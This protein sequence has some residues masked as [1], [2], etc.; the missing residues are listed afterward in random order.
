MA[1]GGNVTVNGKRL[2][3]RLDLRNH[4]PDGFNWGYGGSGPAQLALAILAHEFGDDQ[5]ALTLYQPFKWGVIAP[6]QDNEWELTSQ[7]INAWVIEHGRV[8]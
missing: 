5:A 3:T 4:S 2:P 6:I 7:D 8:A 1:G